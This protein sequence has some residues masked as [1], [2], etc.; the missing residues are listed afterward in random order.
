MCRVLN[1]EG[2]P[3]QNKGFEFDEYLTFGPSF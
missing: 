3:M 2:R 1:S